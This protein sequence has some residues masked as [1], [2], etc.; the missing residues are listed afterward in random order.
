VRKTIRDILEGAPQVGIIYVIKSNVYIEGST[1]RQA[2]E[3]GDFLGHPGTHYG[4]WEKLQKAYPGLSTFDYVVFPRGRVVYNKKNKQFILY[5][6]K[7]IVR[8]KKVVN[9]IMSDMSLP[10]ESTKIE[11]DE[12]YKCHKCGAHFMHEYE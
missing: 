5:L 1:L 4:Y 9:R 10:F 12:H 7:D 6:D 8:N 3:M 2:E 11:V